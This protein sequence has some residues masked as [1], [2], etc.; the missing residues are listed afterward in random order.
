M[1]NYAIIYGTN[2]KQTKYKSQR[3]S[4]NVLL[5]DYNETWR[6]RK[7]KEKPSLYMM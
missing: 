2:T 6:K 3:T 5:S 4:D 7:K 1:K